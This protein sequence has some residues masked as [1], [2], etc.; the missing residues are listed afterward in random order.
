MTVSLAL[1]AALLTPAVAQAAPAAAPAQT[2]AIDPARLAAAKRTLAT[3]LPPEKRAAMFDTILAPMMANIQETVLSSP[4]AKAALGGD[5]KGVAIL[6]RFIDKQQERTRR[7]LN[8][9]LPDMF[10]AMERAYA[11]RFTAAQLDEVT[12]FFNTSTGRFYMDQSLTIMSDPDVLAWQ[13]GLMQRGMASIEEDMKT[14][15]KEIAA[16]AGK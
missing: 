16:E 10:V 14:L 4:S 1:L 2:E 6:Q 9:A 5:P 3:L 12:A 7:T 13:R 15:Q 8:D 11:R